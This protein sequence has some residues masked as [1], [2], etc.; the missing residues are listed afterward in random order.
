MIDISTQDKKDEV[1]AHFKNLILSPGWLLYEQIVKENIEVARNNIL[2]GIA[3][4]KL[5]DIKRL[6]DILAVQEEM[7]NTP[8]KM[9]ESLSNKV[10]ILETDEDPY[11]K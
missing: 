6:R 2:N 7:I 1:V 10:E 3:N 9:I 8:Q 11:Q 5:S 4:E